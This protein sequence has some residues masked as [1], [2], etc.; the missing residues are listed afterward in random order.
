[1]KYIFYILLLSCFNNARS[2]EK[3][4]IDKSLT[5]QLMSH[6]VYYLEDETGS[7]TFDSV[8][9]SKEFRL[10]PR[11]I[12]NFQVSGSTFWLKFTIANKDNIKSNFLK[13]GQPLL[14]IL[15]FYFPDVH[16]NYRAL[17]GG[18]RFRF[19][20]RRYR[21][22]AEFIFDL[23]LSPGQEKTYYLKIKGAG[24]V[25][26]P[27]LVVTKDTMDASL[28]NLTLWIGIYCGII[29]VM[30]LYNI[31]IFLSIRDRSYLYYVFH[32]LFVGLTQLSLLG[33][34]YKYFWPNSPWFAN[35][36]N[37]LFTCLVSIVGVQ[38]LIEFMHLKQKATG[39]FRFLKLIQLIYV[40]YLITSLAG[41]Y[42]ATY[43]A[44]LLTQSFIAVFILIISIYLYKQ[45]FAEAKYYLIGWSSLMLGILIYVA[46]DYGWLP[47]N[48]FT[49][50]SLL[51]GSAAEVTLLS[52][53]LADKINIYKSEKAKMQ[54]EAL[55]S[56]M[57]K[58][59]MVREQNVMLEN[60]VQERTH[61]LSVSNSDLSKVLKD[62]K[63]AEGYLVESEKMAALGQ[64]TAGIAH[65]INNP[66]NFVSSNVTPLKRDVDMLT[67][68]ID[69]FENVGLSEIPL[70]EKQKRIE[71]FKEQ[72][73]LDYLKVEIGHLIKGIQEGALRTAEIV[74]GL[75]IFSRVDE[76]DL[77]EAS[78]NEGLD[79]TIILINNLLTKVELIKVYG[80][81]PMIECY[82]GKL[83]QVFLNIISNAIHAIK[84]RH[85]DKPGGVLKIG[86][87][88]TENSVL[89]TITD[90]GTG[91]DENTKKKIFEPFFT[92]KD[93]GEGT[94]L[95][96]SIA[97][98]IIKKHNGHLNIHSTLGIGSEF[99][100]DLPIIHT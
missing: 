58:E 90:N 2:Q 23:N 37:F 66:I 88:R 25:R 70:P 38:F 98:N 52:F 72:Y 83:N 10:F 55:N 82:P 5:S 46:M 73:D 91:M 89:V 4:V 31:F 76:D 62:L 35:Y 74:K 56:L 80:E 9:H 26:V 24:Q 65:E 50:Y 84:K 17:P 60:K 78:I 1:M 21:Q 22:S 69:H 81:I 61:E 27:L 79:S 29:I 47:F 57:E 43:G 8:Q 41:Y 94:G 12:V 13:V 33:I 19:P 96:M 92:T 93:V 75:R 53:A 77:K 20:E 45:G 86:T 99:I 14:N 32:T 3:V 64:L 48:N 15:D 18:I 39:L 95:G 100:L 16:G 85:G 49:G 36:S 54:Q 34:T 51:F 28:S 63:D 97:Y 42:H 30:V 6:Q 11:E 68:I 87:S 59:R 71:A 44:I 7:V 40:L 67:E